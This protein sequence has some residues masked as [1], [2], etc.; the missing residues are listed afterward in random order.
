M[1]N[2]YL[3]ALE[4]YAYHIHHV[5]ILSQ[6]FCGK[7]RFDAF[8]KRPGDVN[9]RRD[10]AERLS[11]KFNL[12]IQSDHFGNGRSL[13]MEGSSVELF[14]AAAIADAEANP[15]VDYSNLITME[16]ILISRTNQSRMP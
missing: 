16:S 3:P 9:T 2:Y 12:E 6:D 1:K 7:D 14:S 5:Q 13:S 4:K 11:A 15:A 8:K 10:Y